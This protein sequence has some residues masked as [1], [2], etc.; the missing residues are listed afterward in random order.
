MSRFR[1]YLPGLRS[2]RLPARVARAP[3]KNELEMTP[4][5]SS[6]EPMS[7]TPDAFGIETATRPAPSPWKG[8]NSD[9]RNQITATARIAKTA[10]AIRRRRVKPAR[11][12]RGSRGGFGG[13]G[14]FGAFGAFGARSARARGAGFT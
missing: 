13:F 1:V 11:G 14:S 2:P 8:W 9:H 4:R 12:A 7:P 5:F 6:S 3:K 10:S